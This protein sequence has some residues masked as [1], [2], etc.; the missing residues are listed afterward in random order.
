M[1]EL[2]LLALAGGVG[3]LAYDSY[4]KSKDSG[5][6]NRELPPP[7]PARQNAPAVATD[8][9][10]EWGAVDMPGGFPEVVMPAGGGF[11]G[12]L[13]ERFQTSGNC[14]DCEGKHE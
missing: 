5:E 13:A 12:A 9:N 4:Q 6:P 11:F 1:K 8:F 14:S 7:P 2:L 3:Y 10:P